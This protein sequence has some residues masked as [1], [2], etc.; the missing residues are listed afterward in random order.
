MADETTAR[1]PVNIGINLV[2]PEPPVRVENVSFGK[3]SHLGSQVMMDLG[4]LD[5]Q[6]LIE[7][8]TSGSRAGE[9]PSV[10]AYV[11]HRFSMSIE[12]FRL[13]KANLDEIVTK[14][15]KTGVFKD[16]DGP[17]RAAGGG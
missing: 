14:M 3:F 16:D 7:L 9:T 5:D 6:H 11:V 15:R 4:V 8:I 12:T 10:N 17:Q 2:Y 13:L 1:K